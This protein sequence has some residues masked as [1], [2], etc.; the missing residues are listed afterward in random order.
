MN[1]YPVP[2]R[3]I[4][5]ALL[6]GILLLVGI[7]N[8]RERALW[9]VPTDG[10]FWTEDHGKLTA[11]EIQPDSPADRANIRPGDRL[12]S[13]NNREI[14][15]LGQY[16]DL[17]FE[18]GSGSAVTYKLENKNGSRTVTFQLI[19]E[20]MLA[21]RDVFRAILAFLHLGI[22]LF[23]LYKG[24]RSAQSY[25]FYFICLAAF[26]VYFYS[27]TVRLNSLDWWVYGFSILAF[28]LLPA[29]FVHFCLR[30]PSEPLINFHP[31][32]EPL[33]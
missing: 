12:N 4:A 19:A 11:E 7:M 27:W 16:S 10:V 9:T 18:L 22:G 23:V 14:T 31:L 26:V 29:L 25:H 32:T 15:N 28:L 5:T 20:N 6:S 8:F 24:I 30:F 1:A 17:I 13:V 2:F 33:F 3:F 21:P